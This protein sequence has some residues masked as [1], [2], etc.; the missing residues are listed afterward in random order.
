MIDRSR[1][2]SHGY[3]TGEPTLTEGMLVD[4]A[5]TILTALSSRTALKTAL[6]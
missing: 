1:V 3:E 6:E 5:S 2:I 4:A